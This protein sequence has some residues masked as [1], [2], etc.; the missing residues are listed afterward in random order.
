MDGSVTGPPAATSVPV[1]VVQDP[2][3]SWAVLLVVFT[4]GV[5]F[6]WWLSTWLASQ[7]GRRPWQHHQG[8]QTSPPVPGYA[9]PATGGARVAT[10][11]MS[12][13]SQV[14]YKWWWTQPRFQPLASTAH[15][16]TPADATS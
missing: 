6:G 12:T 8:T 2:S 7:D 14:T 1:V 13:M 10:R 11:T 3:G 9:V 15:G 16:A 5:A 4:L